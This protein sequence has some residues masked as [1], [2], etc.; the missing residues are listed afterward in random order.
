MTAVFALLGAAC[1][2]AAFFNPWQL[3]FA[4]MCALMVFVGLEELET[5]EEK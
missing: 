5:E 3:I 1:L 2:V 4:V